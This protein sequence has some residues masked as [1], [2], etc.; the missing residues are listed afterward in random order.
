[1]SSL[2]GVV[3]Y[4]IIAAVAPIEFVQAIGETVENSPDL[5]LLRERVTAFWSLL[6]QGRRRE[7]LEYV[8]PASQDHF[9]NRRSLPFRSFEIRTIH[10]ENPTAVLVTTDVT[11]QPPQFFR[12]IKWPVKE[13][14]LFQ[15]GNWFV[16]VQESNAR[17]LFR[18][19][20]GKR[21]RQ[22]AR[23]NDSD[24]GKIAKE[25][26]RFEIRAKRLILGSL[27]QGD[28]IWRD[29]PYRNDSQVVLSVKITRAPG[30]IAFDKSEFEVEPQGKGT[31]RLGVFTEGLEGKISGEISLS[32]SHGSVARDHT[33]VLEG[34]VRASVAIV[35]A[36]LIVAGSAAHTI[37][38]ENNTDQE[39]QIVRVIP[40]AEFLEVEW[41]ADELPK[42]A[43]GSRVALKLQ[44]E[45]ARIPM[46]W[47]GGS[48]QLQVAAPVAG[49][50]S[51]DILL[52]PEFP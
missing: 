38:I 51:F 17:D 10:F 48:I 33:F 30:W 46:D 18:S 36:R 5:N 47:A 16:Q 9:L 6:Q 27:Q 3:L 37:L 20:R 13:R 41:E 49:R 24:E 11:I 28:V 22:P 4:F 39:L 44:W 7:A 45:A 15:A 26:S 25:L 35:P 34:H 21:S 42:V 12:P 23:I 1:M 14:Y 31:L 19:K 8:E 50:K 29:I 32:I 40:S 2:R 43:P 52:L